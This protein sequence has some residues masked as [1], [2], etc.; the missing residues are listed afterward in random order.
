MNKLQQAEQDIRVKKGLDEAPAEPEA[1]AAP[2]EPEAPAEE[3]AAEEPVTEE[4][5]AD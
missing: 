5:A 4:P 3:P 1:A 2:A